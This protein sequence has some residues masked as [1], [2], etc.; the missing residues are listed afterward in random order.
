V[1]SPVVRHLAERRH[2]DLH[3]IAGTGIGGTIQ[4][5]DVEAASRPRP[6]RPRV[7]PRARRL[8]ERAGVDLGSVTGTGPEGA[9][10]GR[11]IE[12]PPV[13]EVTPR[14]ERS[15]RAATMQRRI[16]ELMERSNREIPHYWVTRDIDFSTAARW[17]T[18]HNE[19]LPPSERVVGAAL[20]LTATARAAGSV[21]NFNGHWIDGTFAPSASVDLGIVVVLRTGGLLVPVVHEAERVSA[22]GMMQQMGDLVRRARSGHLRSSDLATP[23]ITVSNLGDQGADSVL[24]VIYPPQVALVGFGRV[25]ERPWAERGMVGVRPVVRASLAGD[26][27]A[28]DGHQASR[29]L[30]LIDELLQSPD[31]LREVEQ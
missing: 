4:R 28:S 27:R 2:V 8:A 17:L 6:A 19:A 16:A 20:L 13:V 24:G 29:F 3:S 22:A 11:D 15:D 31:A 25:V 7:S 10:V 5:A 23:T 21:P 14:P 1:L 18:A 30:A 9:I 12:S 26:H